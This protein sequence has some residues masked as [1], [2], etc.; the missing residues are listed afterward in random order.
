VK[1]L[2]QP[3]GQVS[4]AGGMRAGVMSKT[5]GRPYPGPRP[6]TVSDRDW[7]FGRAVEAPLLAESWRNN[8]LTFVVGPAGRGKSSLLQAGVLPL[9]ADHASDVLPLGRLSYGATFPSALL[10]NNRYTF[11]L[12]CSWSP[13][14]IASQFDG[15]SLYEFLRRRIGKDVVLAAIDPIDDLLADTGLRRIQRHEFLGQL[16]EALEREPRLHLLI[17]GREE[18]AE[19]VRDALG[20]G[21]RF[22]VA[23]LPWQGAVEAVSKPMAQSGRSFADGAAEKLVMDLQT[24]RIVGDDGSDRRVTNDRVEPT[25]LQMV[26]AFLWD[27]LP[28]DVDRITVRDVRRYGDA[29]TAL[30]AY[31]GTVIAEVADDHDLSAKRLGSWL[32]SNF[33][34]ELGTRHKA[35]EGA[36]A[37]AGMPNA[38]ARALESRHLLVARPQNG[39]RWYELL[40]DRLIEPLRNASVARPPSA[41]PYDHL[42]AAE[43]AWTMGELDLAE[44]YA[45]E[46]IRACP[47]SNPRLRAEANSLLGSLAYEREKPEEAEARYREAAYLHGAVGDNRAVAYQLAAVGQTLQ[48]QGRVTEAVQELHT[49]VARLPNDSVVQTELALAL[50]HDGKGPAAVAVLNDVLRVDG[51]NRAAL[52]TRGEILAYLGD[53]REAMRDLDRVSLQ[54]HPSARAARGLALAGLGDQRAARREIE[55]ALTEGPRN[56]LVLLY[57]ARA[58]ALSGDEGAAQELAQQAADATDPPLSPR[59]REIAW[60]LV[61]QPPIGL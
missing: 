43:H 21:A 60:Q 34:T 41:K 1:V 2:R 44:R 5:A 15:L 6:F 10:T 49:A 59:H 4:L 18:A 9:L 55:N 40:S 24:S 3:P 38:V 7:F 31:C 48:V 36:T 30:A 11:T 8:R 56:G 53:A 29:D 51:S 32:L 58:F 19:V 23:A 61:R 22:D 50:W 57:A 16:E 37:T 13:Y 26:C 14:E 39:S 20:G 54:G 35:Y 27:S 28:I 45:E 47:R 42:Q 12:L 25:L 52:R 46:I 33:V 17:V